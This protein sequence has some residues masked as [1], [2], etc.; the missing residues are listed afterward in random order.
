LDTLT[1]DKRIN[2]M[3]TVTVE[4]KNNYGSVVYYPADET[5]KLFAQLLGTKTLTTQALLHIE[6]L[7]YEIVQVAQAKWRA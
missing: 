5:A 7:G 2:T 4:R 3:K 6:E 1:T